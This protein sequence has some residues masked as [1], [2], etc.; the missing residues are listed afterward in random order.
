MA[1]QKPGQRQAGS[2]GPLCGCVTCRA[3][4]RPAWRQKLFAGMLAKGSTS[5]EAAVSAHKSRLFGDLTGTVLE[6]GPGPG[7]NLRYLRPGATWVGVEPNPFMIT[8]VEKEAL[9]LG[10]TAELTLGEAEDLPLPNHSVDHVISS[11]VL[12]SVRDVAAT[13]MEVRRVLKPGGTF[14]F[15]EHVA[16]NDDPGVARWQRRLNGLSRFVGDGCNI[17][18]R[19]WEQ[20]EAAGFLQ[21]D[22]AHLT[23][24][25]PLKL[26]A[27]HI[28]GTALN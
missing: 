18:R 5:Y 2:E 1:L 8:Y 22:I 20:I 25:G 9:R 14:R 23:V 21:V 15:I 10:L 4:R 6:I 19:T 13:L 7:T 17:D 24:P 16:S 3:M 28:A 26:Y 27:P 11:L 12:C